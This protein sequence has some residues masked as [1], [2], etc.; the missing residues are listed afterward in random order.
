[1]AQISK[2]RGIQWQINWQVVPTISSTRLPT[3][4]HLRFVYL[5]IQ[6]TIMPE[7]TRTYTLA[8][9]SKQ[10]EHDVTWTH[11]YFREVTSLYSSLTHNQQHT[12]QWSDE[13]TV[14]TTNTHTI[15]QPWPRANHAPRQNT[16]T[17]TYIPVHTWCVTLLPLSNCYLQKNRNIIK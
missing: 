2:A 7:I 14:A 6:S 13:S 1:M 12:G 10:R 16:H 15:T 3:T 11:S 5:Y 9:S 17:D 4:I 8:S